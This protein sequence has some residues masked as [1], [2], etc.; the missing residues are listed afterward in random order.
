MIWCLSNFQFIISRFLLSVQE[1]VHGD[2]G[3]TIPSLRDLL[4]IES[5]IVGLDVMGVKMDWPPVKA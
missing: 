2:F 5:D 3:R 4:N 1:F